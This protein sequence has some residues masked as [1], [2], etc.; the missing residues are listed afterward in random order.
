MGKP[1]RSLAWSSVIAGAGPLPR[2]VAKR[3]G[4]GENR[5][6]PSSTRLL[7]DSAAGITPE[8]L[9]LEASV[10]AIDGN[11]ENKRVGMSGCGNPERTTNPGWVPP[12]LTSPLSS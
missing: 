5:F 8:T 12:V 11:V 7:V 10:E 3:T 4:F 2:A 6:G 1:C 9:D